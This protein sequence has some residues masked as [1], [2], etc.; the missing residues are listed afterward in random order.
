M[1]PVDS[2]DTLEYSILYRQWRLGPSATIGGKA[3][4]S[5]FLAV[6]RK[7]LLLV[8]LIFLLPRILPIP[9]DTAVFLAEPVAD[10][11]AVI[12]TCVMFAVVFGHMVRNWKA[13]PLRN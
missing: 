13:D 8:P 11:L 5:L 2:L 4:V 9:Q 7:I 12:T 10:T 1:P 3:G 6:L